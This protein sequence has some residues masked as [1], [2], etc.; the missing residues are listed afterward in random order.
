MVGVAWCGTRTVEVVERKENELSSGG[1]G[2]G[3][4]LS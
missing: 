1:C 2:F 3:G 4:P